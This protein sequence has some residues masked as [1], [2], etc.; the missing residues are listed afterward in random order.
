MWAFLLGGHKK[1]GVVRVRSGVAESHLHHVRQRSLHLTPADQPRPIPHHKGD[2]PPGRFATVEVRVRHLPAHPGFAAVV[3]LARSTRGP[4]GVGVVDL[5][6]DGLTAVLVCCG[7][8]MGAT[9]EWGGTLKRR[10]LFEPISHKQ[11]RDDS[12]C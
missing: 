9:A 11:L 12:L 5:V 3:N 2:P 1:N 4:G 8:D 7:V 10:I 6:G